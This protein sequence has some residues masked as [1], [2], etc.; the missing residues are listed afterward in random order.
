MGEEEEELADDEN[1]DEKKV[2]KTKKS[3]IER[4]IDNVL[5]RK[6]DDDDDLVTKEEEGEGESKNANNVV[7]K[8]RVQQD[9]VESV[10]EKIVV[11]G[12]KGYVYFKTK[13][14]HY[15]VLDKI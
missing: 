12:S 2:A 1:K 8:E 10:V 3:W 6:D 14:E 13:P 4:Q 7:E 11:K 5:G 15:F 9:L